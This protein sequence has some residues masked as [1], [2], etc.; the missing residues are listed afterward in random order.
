MK[1]YLMLLAAVTLL[2][3]QSFAQATKEYKAGHIFSIT[4]PDYLARTTGLSDAASFQY[5]NSVK[6]AYG[7]IIIDDRAELDIMELK[8]SSLKEFYDDF[9]STFLDGEEKRTISEAKYTT[10]AGINYVECDASYY[11]P[12]DK[13][14]I[15]YLVGIMETKTAFYKVVSWC[16]AEDKD[17]YKAD[18]QKILYS[19]HE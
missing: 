14:S 5:K 7:I 4:L 16:M 17:K 3:S 8:F 13:I 19:V 10:K 6:E 18:F 9:I 1:K 15:Y 12:E 11:D 2:A